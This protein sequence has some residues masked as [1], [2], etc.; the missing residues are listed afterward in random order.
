[1]RAKHHAHHRHQRGVTYP[2]TWWEKFYSILLVPCLIIL[3]VLFF[4]RGPTPSPTMPVL[5][6]GYLGFAF[7]QTFTRLLI[8]Y[9]IS[10]A[11][12]IPLGLL[13]DRNALAERLLLPLFDIVQS[14]PVLAFFPIIIAFFVQ[15]GFSDGAAIFILFLSMLWNIVFSIVSGLKTIP[16]DIK[17]A[18]HIFDIRGM[19]Y[20]THVLLPAIVPYLVTG[21]LLAWAQGW[22]IIIVVEVL[23]QY[24]PGGTDAQDLFGIGSVMVHA[25]AQ[26]RNDIFAASIGFLIL[27]IAIINLLVWQNLLHYAERFKFD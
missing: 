9:V 16:E 26:G 15:F 7:V 6:F 18:A 27:A 1:M 5:T 14:V 4:Y 24:I 2:T 22:N 11:V 19:R 17:D 10:L 13:A 3:A 20:T 25:I 21:S 23:H 12:A 8:A